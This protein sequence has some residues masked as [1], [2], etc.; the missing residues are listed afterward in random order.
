MVLLFRAGEIDALTFDPVCEFAIEGRPL[1][2]SN[3]RIARYTAD[4]AYIEKGRT[5]WEEVKPPKKKNKKGHMVRF[6]VSRDVPLRLAL[7]KHLNPDIEL[8]VVD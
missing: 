8:R 1:K 3:G 2:M 7:F 6:G 5:V 4:F